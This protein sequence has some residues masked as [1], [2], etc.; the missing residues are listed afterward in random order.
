MEKDE[1]VRSRGPPPHPTGQEKAED[2]SDRC[3]TVIFC[4][5]VSSKRVISP[6]HQDAS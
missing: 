5:E 1:N 3:Q 2:T 4:A 6:P